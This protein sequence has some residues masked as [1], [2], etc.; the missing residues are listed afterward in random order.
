M[1]A[2]TASYYKVR[3]RHTVSLSASNNTR[4]KQFLEARLRSSRKLSTSAI[5]GNRFVGGTAI[6]K[7][8][9]G[10][11][12]AIIINDFESLPDVQNDVRHQNAPGPGAS[13]FC[14]LNTAAGDTSKR[15]GTLGVGQEANC[16]PSGK[17]K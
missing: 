9:T 4:Q 3:Q 12:G 17:K 14:V 10:D 11:E 13:P 1:N 6:E 8:T 7:L 5:V 15:P 2:V 16:W